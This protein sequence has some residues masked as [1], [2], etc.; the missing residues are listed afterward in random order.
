MPAS[1]WRKSIVPVAGVSPSASSTS[2]QRRRNAVPA[3][4][5]TTARSLRGVGE[6]WLSDHW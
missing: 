2:S 6:Y 4:L 1:V 5:A 3:R